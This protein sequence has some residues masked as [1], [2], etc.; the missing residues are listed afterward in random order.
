MPIYFCIQIEMIFKKGIRIL[1]NDN[2]TVTYR[3]LEQKEQFKK[4]YKQLP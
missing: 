1:A 4:N 2:G 3:A